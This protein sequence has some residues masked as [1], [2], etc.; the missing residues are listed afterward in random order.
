MERGCIRRGRR[1]ERLHGGNVEE[2][3]C[4][5]GER[6]DGIEERRKQRLH[7]ERRGGRGNFS[8]AI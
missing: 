5:I 4:C 1:G 6:G 7:G 2:E 3:G 8:V